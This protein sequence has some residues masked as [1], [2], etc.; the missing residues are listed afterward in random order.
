MPYSKSS[1]FIVAQISDS[2]LFSDPSSCHHGVN[3]YQNLSAVLTDIKNNPRINAVVFTGDLTHDH[4][5]E[6]YKNFAVLVKKLEIN[7]PFYFLAGNHDEPQLLNRYLQDKPFIADKKVQSD[8]WQLLLV[9]TKSETPAGLFDEKAHQKLLS[10]VD[11][12]KNTFIFMHHHPIDVG[13]F[14][15]RHHLKNSTVFWQS[16]KC[17]PSLKGISCGHVHRALEFPISSTNPIAPLYTCPATS[18]QFDPEA[19]TVRALQQ[20]AGYRIFSFLN[21]GEINT[22]VKYVESLLL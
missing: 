22:Q 8:H 5:I 17:L 7:V 10:A 9:A 4:S 15:D 18:I 3:V 14:I 13:Y 12:N 11:S 2:H 1:D 6:S 16:I 20:S 21:N 19:D